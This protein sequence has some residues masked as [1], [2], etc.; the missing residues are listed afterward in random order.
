MFKESRLCYLTTTTRVSTRGAIVPIAPTP[1]TATRPAPY[2]A[3]VV[4]P[5]YNAP[6]AVAP[7]PGNYDAQNAYSQYVQQ[8]QALNPSYNPDTTND[9]NLPA[10]P[11]GG[12]TSTPSSNPSEIVTTLKRLS[13]MSFQKMK[14]IG[15]SLSSKQ[16]ACWKI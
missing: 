6:I 9:P 12:A 4:K 15:G 14:G 8:Q 3:P 13:D 2:V 5:T 11:F 1:Q 16:M 7:N 10:N